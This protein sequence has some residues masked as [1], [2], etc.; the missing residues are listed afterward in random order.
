MKYNH[1]NKFIHCNFQ[2]KLKFIINKM[3]DL[4]EQRKL[5]KRSNFVEKFKF[6]EKLIDFEK[7]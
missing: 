7:K 2:L 5:A 3:I 1:L 6:S 4:K